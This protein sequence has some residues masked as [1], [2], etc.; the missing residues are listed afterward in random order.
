M[1]LWIGFRTGFALILAIGAQNAFVLRQGIRREH[2]WAV[3]LVCAVSD[4]LLISLGVSGLGK[5]VEAMPWL[6]PVMRW[7][8]AAFL[9]VYGAK[10][11]IAAWKGGEAMEA[12]AQGAVP[13]GKVIATC[14][15]FTWL[16]P[17]VYLDTVL[18]VGSIS[19]QFPGHEWEF[20]AGAMLA[21][22]V[23]F[24]LLGFGARLVAP[25][26]ANPTAWRVLDVIVGLMMWSVAANLIVRG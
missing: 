10:A 8:G 25:L 7:G 12:D 20:G 24:G 18:L 17:H 4:A 21:S 11:M 5:L 22:F 9:T 6:F 23:F 1:E 3:V 13:L 2:V 15:M 19:T 16:N 26:F 14:L